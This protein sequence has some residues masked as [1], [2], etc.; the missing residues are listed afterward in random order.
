MLTALVLEA[1][2]LGWPNDFMGAFADKVPKHDLADIDEIY[3]AC[4]A[5]RPALIVP[6]KL[7]AVVPAEQ[8]FFAEFVDL[9]AKRRSE[10]GWAGRMVRL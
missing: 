4:S 1:E 7:G 10:V 3:L 6:L 2:E 9:W 5:F 8:P